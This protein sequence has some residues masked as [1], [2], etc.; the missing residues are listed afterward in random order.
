M[1][2][3]NQD[4]VA[5][6]PGTIVAGS[7][8]ENAVPIKSTKPVV[9]YFNYVMHEAVQKLHNKGLW[10]DMGGRYGGL[11]WRLRPFSHP[12]VVGKAEAVEKA[13]RLR[14]KYDKDEEIS[15]EHRMEINRAAIIMA[16][17]G[18]KGMVNV[19][20]PNM[21]S[22][23]PTLLSLVENSQKALAAAQRHGYEIVEDNGLLL[24]NFTGL[25]TEKKLRDVIDPL[26]EAS[27]S[28]LNQL[29]MASNN[30][31]KVKDEEIYG[32]GEA[33]VYGRTEGYDWAD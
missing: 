6:D 28:M 11:M 26:L 18:V 24:V 1:S 30:L 17:T 4:N 23:D 7:E 32:L 9:V 20:N 14:E 21:V 31:R 2:T 15:G 3:E 27:V 13:V 19:G 29:F 5:N 33:Y 22:S 12:A 10:Y 8:P 25:E 16:T